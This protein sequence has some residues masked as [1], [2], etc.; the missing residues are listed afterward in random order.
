MSVPK[1]VTPPRPGLVI[2]LKRSLY[3]LKQAGRYWNQML[4][5]RLIELGLRQSKS[6]PCLF[7]KEDAG[8]LPVDSQR[9]CRSMAD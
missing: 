6:D 8:D 2:K 9:A 1:G 4:S 5:E 3:G 7:L